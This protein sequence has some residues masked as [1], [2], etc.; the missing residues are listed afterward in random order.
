MN[1]V[2]WVPD[3]N[4]A[5]QADAIKMFGSFSPAMVVGGKIS[6]VWPPL[7]LKVAKYCVFGHLYKKEW[8]IRPSLVISIKKK[9]KS[10]RIWS[11][12]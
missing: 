8:Q 6:P 2:S 5:S 7:G 11:S 10:E 3:I 9:G 4:R 1:A 12:P